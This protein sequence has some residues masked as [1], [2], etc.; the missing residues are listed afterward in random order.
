MV[1]P[2]LE[3]V[4]WDCLSLNKTADVAISYTA[5]KWCVSSFA[6]LKTWI[7]YA[8]EDAES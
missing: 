2:K 6:L 7:L 8:M 5:W 4:L 1:E 3:P